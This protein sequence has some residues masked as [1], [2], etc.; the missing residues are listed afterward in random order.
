MRL[1]LHILHLSWFGLGKSLIF[2]LCLQVKV[3]HNQLWLFHG[4][5]AAHSL[6]CH[7]FLEQNIRQAGELLNNPSVDAPSWLEES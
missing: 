5:V 1:I 3:L 6:S 4:A 7:S 2:A